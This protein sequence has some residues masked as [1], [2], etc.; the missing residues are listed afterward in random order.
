MPSC[1][2]RWMKWHEMRQEFEVLKRGK[3]ILP[4]HSCEVVGFYSS[5]RMHAFSSWNRTIRGKGSDHQ[6]LSRMEVRTVV[7]RSSTV[8]VL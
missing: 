4:A 2:Y 5:G 1:R 6:D 3:G 8:T 7:A